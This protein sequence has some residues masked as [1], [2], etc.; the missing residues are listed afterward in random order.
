MILPHRLPFYGRMM[1]LRYFIYSVTDK[2]CCSGCIPDLQKNAFILFCKETVLSGIDIFRIG[3]FHFYLL[4][5]DIF[6]LG[7]LLLLYSLPFLYD[8]Y[9]YLLPVF[10]HSQSLHIPLVLLLLSYSL[11]PSIIITVTHMI[12]R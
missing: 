4:N 12:F 9:C 10:T 11:H 7:L 5:M 1:W 3:S 8:L 6:N 2:I